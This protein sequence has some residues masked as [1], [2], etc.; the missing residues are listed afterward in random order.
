MRF[1]LK[2]VL[3]LPAFVGLV[4]GHYLFLER[5]RVVEWDT[6]GV[7]AAAAIVGSMTGARVAGRLAPATVRALVAVGLVA[8]G[9]PLVVDALA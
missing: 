5:S 2:T 1:S 6:A 3:L 8:A 9:V 4:L 7:V